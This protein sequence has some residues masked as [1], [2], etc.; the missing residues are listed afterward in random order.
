MLG[1]CC[2]CWL[3]LGVWFI[4]LG[5]G[6]LLRLGLVGRFLLGLLLGFAVCFFLGQ[7]VALLLLLLLLLSGS[8][9]FG[10]LVLFQPLEL[11]L[12]FEVCGRLLRGLLRAVFGE[13]LLDVVEELVE[14]L[15]LDFLDLARVSW[16]LG[17]GWGLGGLLDLLLGF[18]RFLLG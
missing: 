16:F 17:F 12:S 5:L 4:L 8:L 7:S 10:G 15:L 13:A 11:L 1:R 3:E 2:R 14:L 9:F 18:L 6:R